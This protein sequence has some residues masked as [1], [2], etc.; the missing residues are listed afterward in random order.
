MKRKILMVILGLIVMSQIPFAYRRYRLRR[1]RNTIQQLAAQRLPPA[2]ESEY[3]DYRGV[4]H[5][6]TFLGGHSTGTFAEL[7]AAAKANQL[8][9]VIM[10]EHPQREFDTSTM[11]LNGTHAGV[12]F[13][14][15][16][17]VAS[18]NGDR[19]LLIPGSSNAASMN[20]QSTQQIVEQQKLSGGLAIAAYP[21][22]SDTWKSSAVDGVEVY[23]LFTNARQIR[24]V[25][26]FFDGLWS[27]RSYA[28]LMFANFFA[29]PDENLRRWDTAMLDANRKL[30]VTAGNDAH[31]N[32]GVSL[33][34]DSGKQ[35][36]GVKLDPYERSF[37]TVRT[38]ILIKK[39]N[40][41]TRESVLQALSLGHCYISFDL[42]GEAAGFSFSVKNS[43]TIMGDE[44]APVANSELV[45]RV[46]LDAR[47]VMIKNGT[48]VGQKQGTSA[49]FPASG[50][51]VYRAE[52]YL[53]SL[54]AP[55]LGKP[56]IISSPIY[57]R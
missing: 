40:G 4:I 43:D 50:P 26:M 22:E 29:R 35:L 23:N 1:L 55:A 27:Y 30:L 42:F 14:N 57:L 46:P 16:N 13:I 45:V 19:L 9:F 2:A 37:R 3:V 17:E 34:D 11:T 12:L 33:N 36:I 5:V 7:I 15:G 52:I 6:H 41:L 24:P 18:A 44:I 10:T 38:H 20:T 47:V 49:E 31:S 39:G 32:V 54:P 48:V 28:D 51:G 25:V 56:W 8:D 21:S 53:D